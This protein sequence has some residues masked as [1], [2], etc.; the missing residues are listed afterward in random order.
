ME[1]SKHFEPSDLKIHLLFCFHSDTKNKSN[2]GRRVN[3]QAFYH[4]L[5]TSFHKCTP[6]SLDL[7][8]RCEETYN[9]LAVVSNFWKKKISVHVVNNIIFKHL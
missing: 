3:P 5:Y 6:P 2:I 7:P 8:W 1:I 4:I 9:L